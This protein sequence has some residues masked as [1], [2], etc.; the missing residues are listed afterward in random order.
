[1][2]MPFECLRSMYADGD[3]QEAMLMKCCMLKGIGRVYGMKYV[4]CKRQLARLN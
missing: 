1:M 3:E 4:K 2:D